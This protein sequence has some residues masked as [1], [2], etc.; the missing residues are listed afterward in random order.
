MYNLSRKL[1]L[2]NIAE[3]AEVFTVRNDRNDRNIA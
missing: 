1:E 2:P 3:K